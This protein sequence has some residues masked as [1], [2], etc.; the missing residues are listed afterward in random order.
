MKLRGYYILSPTVLL[1]ISLLPLDARVQSSSSEEIFSAPQTRRA[2]AYLK[3]IEPETIEEQIRITEI[4]APTFKEQRRAA[5]FKRRF[6]ELGLK[7]VRID[8]V[9]N[10]IGERPGT[11]QGPT[12]VVVAHLDTVFDE[13]TDVKV[14]RRGSQGKRIL[15]IEHFKEIAL[16]FRFRLIR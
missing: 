8:S 9:G 13:S 7:N 16:I 1:L 2:L 14:K 11:E 12:L 6:A 5:Y 4:P 10:V 15:N 3:T